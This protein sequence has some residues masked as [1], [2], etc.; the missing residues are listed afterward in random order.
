MHRLSFS[1]WCFKSV[2]D[3]P[4]VD[5]M[6]KQPARIVTGRLFYIRIPKDFNIFLY[7]GN[8]ESRKKRVIKVHIF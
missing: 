1:A 8:F 2:C 4:I 6:Q 5:Q 3:P 7:V